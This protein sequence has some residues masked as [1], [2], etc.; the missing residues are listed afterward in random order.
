MKVV[1]AVAVWVGIVVLPAM[2]LAPRV[3]LAADA[4]AGDAGVMQFID[5]GT[6][7]V[8]RLDLEKV[9]QDSIEANFGQ[10][11][12]SV[13]K[14]MAVPANRHERVRAEGR[15]AA[16]KVK[17]WISGMK[18]GGVKRVYLLLDAADFAAGTD[19]PIL[20]APLEAN[21]NADDVGGL[22]DQLSSRDHHEQLGSAMVF[23]TSKQRE[24]LKKRLEA[25]AAKVDR[26][27]IA[28]ALAAAG[29]APA[30]IA[31][32]PG[33]VAR[34]F[35]ERALPKQPEMF[36]GGETKVLSRGLKWASV[37]V[38]Q[39]PDAKAHLKVRATDP[40]Q[41]KALLEV[42]NKGTES[43]KENVA[44]SPDAEENTRLLEAIKPKLT[45]ETISV[46]VDPVLIVSG[47]KTAER[48]FSNAARAATPA[49]G[50]TP[51]SGDGGL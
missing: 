41:A 11:S 44:G 42:I 5:T 50:Q 46:D 1:R 16:G 47:I 23:A 2:L 15:E 37:G 28:A 3:A 31:L 24:R 34:A 14:V 9:D 30:R 49:P 8:G 32:V 20:I 12:E 17:D 25:G 40:E 26:P 38:T 51:P 4:A 35:A 48:Q 13:I 45:G 10:M 39:K 29:D 6:F 33:E 22:F 43:A 27:E 18:D 19:D 36:G 7:L 21:A